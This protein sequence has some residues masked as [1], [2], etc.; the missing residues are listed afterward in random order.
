MAKKIITG[1]PKAITEAVLQ[2]LSEAFAMGCSDTEACI[3]ADIATGTLYNYQLAHPGFLEY[4]N[5][6]KDTPML[7]ARSTVVKSLDKPVNAQ[8]YLERKN[9]AEFA[10][11]RDISADNGGIIMIGNILDMLEER[12]IEPKLPVYEQQIEDN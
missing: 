8:W 12:K 1:R 7:K 5:Q 6:L 3:Y 9:K 11:R 4:K 10:L 2:K